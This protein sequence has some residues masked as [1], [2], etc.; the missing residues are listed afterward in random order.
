VV[1]ARPLVSRRPPRRVRALGLALAAI[2]AACAQDIVIAGDDA[3]PTGARD[4]SI[5]DATGAEVDAGRSDAQA[6]RADADCVPA[7]GSRVCGVDPACG[8]TC[9]GCAD[10]EACTGEGACAPSCAEGSFVCTGDSSAY[11]SCGLNGNLGVRDLG[12]RVACTPGTSCAAVGPRRCT[13]AG[14]APPEV[15]LVVDRSASMSFNQTFTWVRD[16]LL[17]AM[18]P[19]DQVGLF[20]LR[21]FPGDRPCTPGPSLALR[22]DAADGLRGGLVPPSADGS[23]PVDAALRDIESMFGPPRDGQGV[24]LVVD[25]GDTCRA[26]ADVTD[27]LSRLARSGIRTWVIGVNRTADPATLEA[28]ARAGGTGQARTVTDRAALD[29][30]LE[31]VFDELGACRDPHAQIGAAYY[32]SCGLGVDGRLECWG[33]DLSRESSPPGGTFTQLGVGNA[34]ACAVRDTGDVACWGR[35]ERGQTLAPAGSFTQLAGGDQHT[36]GLLTDGTARCWGYDDARQATAPAGVRF[37]Q[38]TCGGF[39]SC[40]VRMDDSVECWGQAPLPPSGPVRM[41]D[42]GS[43]HWCAVLADGSIDC[44]NGSASL[45][46]GSDFVA[47][48]AGDDHDCALRQSGEVVCWG[49]GSFGQTTVPPGRYAAVAANYQ[50]TCA[51][52]ADDDRFVCWGD[53]SNGQASPP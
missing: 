28:W 45:P 33:R 3:R 46:T 25:G 8:R 5:Q 53:D 51:V 36:C 35:N 13:G 49:L 40:G 44:S 52:R 6:N 26:S 19:R 10:G 2:T 48:S 27:K 42:G 32:H 30:A 31:A 24:V 38:V 34:H 11:Q 4:A 23:S 9:G 37:K 18:R 20:G 21:T 39:F 43:F 14:C 15:V 17:Q 12:E 7:C 1:P 47:V 22:R 29:A 16:G 41:I 50:H